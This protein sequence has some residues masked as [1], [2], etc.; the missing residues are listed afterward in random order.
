MKLH[1]AIDPDY[2]AGVSAFRQLTAG[3]RPTF[4]ANYYDLY[5]R[6]GFDHL[7]YRGL[8]LR[9]SDGGT[10]KYE[11]FT[12]EA[13]KELLLWAKYN[14]IRPQL[15]EMI[16]RCGLNERNEIRNLKRRARYAEQQDRPK[17]FPT[18]VEVRH[19]VMVEAQ[20]PDGIT[21]NDDNEASG[22][23]LTAWYVREFCRLN[24]LKGA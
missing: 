21:C 22:K 1:P 5:K 4:R 2:P 12:Y 18:I 15:R 14:Q 9:H 10:G 24:N 11:T 6:E 23:G 13:T 20:A 16:G 17:V 8:A 3:A 7:Y 19:R